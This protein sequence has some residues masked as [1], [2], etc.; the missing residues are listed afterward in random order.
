MQSIFKNVQIVLDSE[1][2]KKQAERWVSCITHY[3][4][5]ALNSCTRIKHNTDESNFWIKLLIKNALHI[6]DLQYV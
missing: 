6:I 1:G 5:F 4:T 2:H 3:L